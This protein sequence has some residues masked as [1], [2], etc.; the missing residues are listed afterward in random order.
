MR[1]IFSKFGRLRLPEYQT[2]TRIIEVSIGEKFVEKRS[3]SSA[4]DS[5][6]LRISRRY[7]LYK[8]T[9]TSQKVKLTNL[10]ESNI[11]YLKFEYFEGIN[12]DNKLCGFL[13][14]GDVENFRNRI[15]LYYELISNSFSYYD[16]FKETY[17]FKKFFGDIQN[18]DQI[19]NLKSFTISNLDLNFD[20]IIYDDTTRDYYIYDL[21]WLFSFPVPVNYIFW[22][23][24][25]T[26]SAIRHPELFPS[27]ELLQIFQSFHITE[28][29]IKIFEKMEMGFN[30]TVHEKSPIYLKKYLKRRIKL[31]NLRKRPAVCPKLIKSIIL[32]LKTLFACY[33]KSF[34][35]S[36][37]RLTSRNQKNEYFFPLLKLADTITEEIH[38]FSFKPLV[39]IIMPVHNTNIEFLKSAV[40]SVEKQW[41]ENWELCIADDA[42]NN[43]DTLNYLKSIQGNPK[44][45][46]KFLEK[47]LHISGASNEALSLARGEYIALLDHDDELTPNALYEVVKVINSTDADFIYSDEDTIKNSILC[48]PSFKPDY[49]PDLLLSN[50]YIC[51][52]TV[53]AKTL[54]D[55]VGGFSIGVDGSQ[56]YDLFLKTLEH[57]N[58]IFHIQ[59]VLYHWR[60]HENSLSKSSK[61]KIIPHESGKIALT[62]AIDRR[63]LNATVEDGNRYSFIYR[64]RYKIQ[65]TPLVSIIIPFRDDPKLLS[66]CINSVLNKSSYKNFE[67]IGISNNSSKRDTFETMNLLS[68]KNSQVRFYEYNT[69]FNYSKINNYAVKCHA[70]GEHILLLNNDTEIITEDWIES[71]LEHSQRKEV[72][73]VGALLLYPNNRVQHAG[74]I[75]G[76]GEIASHSHQYW[77]IC[78]RGYQGRLHSVQNLSAVTGACLMI[79]KSLYQELGG[80][81]EN[82]AIAFNDVDF[83]LRLREK[84][85]LNI[86]T[87]Y[88]KLYHYEKASRKKPKTK[89][90]KEQKK[91]EASYMRKRHTEIFKNGDPYYNP[92]LSLKKS[93]FTLK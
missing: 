66:K 67:I 54:I 34:R 48:D 85:H 44:I 29:Q 42:S 72:G 19:R 89:E 87:P 93:G 32:R 80:L 40:E 28:A 51:H 45:R 20:N 86:Y 83:C 74:V 17:E 52:L 27:H 61:T 25:S 26:F 23:A 24:L 31:P 3:F 43:Q 33:E 8:T 5:H 22:R 13:R 39:S 58:K 4:S 50:N 57:T 16:T 81:N 53:I 78:R 92:N 73:A 79:K 21:D 14:E 30:N 7:S 47:N 46:M 82:L 59:K 11:D 88:C 1:C 63:G 65:E 76:L 15:K 49:S 38:S 70:K 71:L 64:I 10:L 60:R 2:S 62:R 75:L 69:P 77:K 91:A 9:I 41:Y 18:L 68:Q 56:D 6:L 35:G 55:K 12:L 84:E 90:D 37:K 36:F